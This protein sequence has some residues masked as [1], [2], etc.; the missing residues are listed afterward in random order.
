MTTA[1]GQSTTGLQHGVNVA[2]NVVGIALPV[3]MALLSVPVLVKRL[4]QEG[5]AVLTLGWAVVGSLGVLDLGLGKALTIEIGQREDYDPQ[6]T[7]AVIRKVRRLLNGIGFAWAVLLLAVYPLLVTYWPTLSAQTQSPA[8]A[9]AALVLCIPTTIWL[10]SSISILEAHSRFV[11]VNAVRIPLGVATYLAPL[12]TAT[13]TQDIAWIFGSLLASRIA[14]GAV[15]AWMVREW[16]VSD[17]A[18]TAV[19]LRRILLSGGWMTVTQAVGPF[20]LYSDRFLIAATVS[21]AAVT[22]YALPFD[23]LIRLPMLPIAVVA[24]LFPLFVRSHAHTELPQDIQRLSQNTVHLLLMAWLGTVMVVCVYAHQLLSAWIGSELA[25]RSAA[26]AQWLI[27][28]VALNGLAHVPL[29]LLQSKGRAD[30]PARLLL[31]QLLPYLLAL[32]WAV[33]NHGILGAAVVWSARAAADAVLLHAAA[34]VIAT[35]W[36]PL[37]RTSLLAG[38]GMSSACMGIALWNL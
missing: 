37:L 12:L 5:F 36:R 15:S 13:Q 30:I 8:A 7:R 6:G 14:A 28:G 2:L 1:P 16:S 10:N 32:Y 29:S 9:W 25:V 22:H 19:D 24:V 17:G 35:P 11:S 20:F 33:Q 3:L 31:A 23:V 18:R 4:G 38:L 21:A 27:V 26:V 34:W